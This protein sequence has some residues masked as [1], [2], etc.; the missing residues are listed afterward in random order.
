MWIF[1]I[2]LPLIMWENGVI[3]LE[4]K[5]RF[6]RTQATLRAPRSIRIVRSIITCHRVLLQA[7]SFSV[8]HSMV[9]PLKRQTGWENHLM[10]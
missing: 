3:R 7:N 6:S 5:Q 1:G 4:I 10:V 2:C 9:V 8:C